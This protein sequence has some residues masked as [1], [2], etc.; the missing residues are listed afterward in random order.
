MKE[1]EVP[2]P[3]MTKRNRNNRI[4]EEELHIGISRPVVLGSPDT[5]ITPLKDI[6]G[7]GE[8]IADNQ[9][10]IKF[11]KNQDVLC[12]QLISEELVVV[13]RGV[14]VTTKDK[15]IVYISDYK[16]LDF[17]IIFKTNSSYR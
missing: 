15:N 5:A 10:L 11:I 16:L 17:T 3:Y 6:I 14:G 8:V 7:M 12:S 13:P 9:L 4:Y 1:I 2:L